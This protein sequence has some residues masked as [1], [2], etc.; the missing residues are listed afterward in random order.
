MSRAIF[1]MGGEIVAVRL[2]VV[3]AIVLVL[4]L[5]PTPASSSQLNS[6]CSC[7]NIYP[8]SP[9]NRFRCQRAMSSRLPPALAM[10]QGLALKLPMATMLFIMPLPSVSLSVSFLPYFPFCYRSTVSFLMPRYDCL[11][12]GIVGMKFPQSS[13]CMSCLCSSHSDCHTTKEQPGAVIV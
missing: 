1:M 5:A 4:T 3:V 6:S 9:T 8:P 13:D 12:Y 10:Q 2:G 11:I 7:F